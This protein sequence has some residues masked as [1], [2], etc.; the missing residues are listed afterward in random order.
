MDILR[1]RTQPSKDDEL[2]KKTHPVL[3]DLFSMGIRE[4]EPKNI[5]LG[6]A[7]MLLFTP[8]SIIMSIALKFPYYLVL[9]VFWLLFSE[10]LEQIGVGLSFYV[11]LS[12]IVVNFKDIGTE[13]GLAFAHVLNIAT[14]GRALQRVCS[15]Y[16][17][18][19]YFSE[20]FLTS[21]K[22]SAPITSFTAVIPKKYGRKY[23][24]LIELHISANQTGNQSE[25]L[26]AIN[27]HQRRDTSA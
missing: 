18:G 27:E 21:E 26:E 8:I 4:A 16:L 25:L 2:F 7:L 5:V 3:L 17:S 6:S 14:F 9:A 12:V 24:R 10:D 19:G 13:V 15:G 20:M 22:M 11:G 23:D 1:K